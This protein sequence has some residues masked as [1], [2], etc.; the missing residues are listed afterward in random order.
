MKDEGRCLCCGGLNE[1]DRSVCPSCRTKFAVQR[2]A[3]NQARME[4]LRAVGQEPRKRGAGGFAA[5]PENR[6]QASPAEQ[7][8]RRRKAVKASAIKRLSSA[9]W[10]SVDAVLAACKAEKR[11]DPTW[12]LVADLYDLAYSRGYAAGK[13]AR[14]TKPH[15]GETTEAA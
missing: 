1:S 3:R 8:T 15:T 13:A 5:P 9:K 7:E 10:R 14:F 11:T 6:Y 2:S 12:A 4:R